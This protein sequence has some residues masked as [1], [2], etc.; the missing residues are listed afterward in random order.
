MRPKSYLNPSPNES[1]W[2]QP[3]AQTQDCLQW[4]PSQIWVPIQLRLFPWTVLIYLSCYILILYFNYTPLSNCT[5]T[6]PVQSLTFSE[7]LR[8]SSSLTKIPI[9][10]LILTITTA[11]MIPF[12]PY[13]PYLAKES[14][15]DLLFCKKYTRARVP[16]LSPK[17]LQDWA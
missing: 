8:D 7:S 13:K 4:R 3:S 2:N 10:N 14:K 17:Q 15:P 11:E 5:E 6:L 12:N 1:K 9:P 16:V